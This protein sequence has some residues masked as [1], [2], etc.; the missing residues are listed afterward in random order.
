MDIA[1]TL[2]SADLN[3]CNKNT[4]NRQNAQRKDCG[5]DKHADQLAVEIV[6]QLLKMKYEEKT[7]RKN[8]IPTYERKM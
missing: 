4:T 5:I 2:D 1:V 6:K 7:R 8:N 3:L